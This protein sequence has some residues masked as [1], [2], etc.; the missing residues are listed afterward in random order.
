MPAFFARQYGR[1]P[2][3]VSRTEK[4][5]GLVI[6]ILTMGIVVAFAVQVTTNQDYL[7]TIDEGDYQPRQKT[8]TRPIETQKFP[9]LN[10]DDWQPPARAD[11]YTA[12]N[13]YLKINGRAETYLQH[14]VVG[15]TF[16]TY[17]YQGEIDRT[18]DVYWYDMGTPA[19]ALSIYRSEE[20][21]GATPVSIGQAAYQVGG[22]VF[23][24]QGS[25]YVQIMPAQLNDADAALKV[26]RHLAERI[27]K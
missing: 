2:E 6:L 24:C 9:A 15:L 11:L 13:L 26:A 12:E 14:H 20:A 21:P 7:F 5:L 27:E 8:H 23:F 18:V 16:G 3:A 10:Y 25:S 17:R 19:N 22:A 4:V 1:K